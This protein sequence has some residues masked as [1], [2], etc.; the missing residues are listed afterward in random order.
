MKSAPPTGV[1]GRLTELS[2]FETQ[3]Y[4]AE[5]EQWLADAQAAEKQAG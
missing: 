2:H 5:A 1:D 4:V 3:F